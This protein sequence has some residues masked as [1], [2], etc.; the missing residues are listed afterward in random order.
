MD[1][2]RERGRGRDR[3]RDRKREIKDPKLECM[4]DPTVMRISIHED[5]MY[6]LSI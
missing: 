1:G 5:P 4:E 3:E 6:M 2:E